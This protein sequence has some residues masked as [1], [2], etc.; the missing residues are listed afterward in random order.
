MTGPRH[1]AVAFLDLFD[2]SPGPLVLS[3]LLG[4]EKSTLF[5]F[6]LENECFELVT[7][8][9]DLARI[10][11]I[12]DRQLPRRDDAFALVADVEQDLVAVDTNDR[13]GD[14]LAI[15]DHDHRGCV[16]I[17]EGTLEIVGR[18]LARRIAVDRAVG[19]A[20]AGLR[21]EAAVTFELFGVHFMADFGSGHGRESVTFG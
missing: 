7:D 14:Q 15:I 16:G 11:V 9:N 13:A 2:G 18:D 6:L 10:D 8:R 4:E 12:A 20:V 21:I 19:V 5:V 1:D 17:V 3:P